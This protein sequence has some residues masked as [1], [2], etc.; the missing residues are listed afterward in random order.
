MTLLLVGAFGVVGVLTRYLAGVLALDYFPSEFPLVTLAINVLGSLA[1]GIVATAP[2]LSPALKIGIVVGFL[3]GFTTF[4][5]FS[6]DVVRLIE[7]GRNGLA[8]GYFLV[9]PA[10]G[11]AAAFLGLYL[12]RYFFSVTLM[13]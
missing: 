1:I 9:S 5:S 6:L 7:N 11:V 10:L 8:L 13:K 3:G 12:G 2:Q 4:S